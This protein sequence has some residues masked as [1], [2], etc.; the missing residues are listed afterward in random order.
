MT[1]IRLLRELL[2]GTSFEVYGDPSPIVCVK[3]GMEGL[4]RL[5]SRRLPELGLLANLVEFP[6]VPKG[7][8]RFRMQVMANHS[9]RDIIDAV[10]RMSVARAEAT[11]Q[12]DALLSGAIGFDAIDALVKSA[13]SPLM[14]APRAGTAE[15]D[16]AS[17]ARLSAKG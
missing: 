16:A 5:V 3:M 7:Q 17:D 14:R 6:A 1:N 13:K 12:H 10:H 15:A 11:E 9:S 4:A 8:A 2:Q